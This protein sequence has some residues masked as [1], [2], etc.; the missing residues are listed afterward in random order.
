MYRKH[1]GCGDAG[2][3]VAVGCFTP[4]VGFTGGASCYVATAAAGANCISA[5]AN[6]VNNCDGQSVGDTKVEV[7]SIT[8]HEDCGDGTVPG[9]QNHLYKCESIMAWGLIRVWG[10]Q[11]IGPRDCP[12]GYF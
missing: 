11:S 6:C 1:G 3:A 12:D 7:E 4:A 5:F 10:F 9:T 8:C 2:G